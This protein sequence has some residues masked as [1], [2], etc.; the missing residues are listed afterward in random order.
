M[1]QITKSGYYLSLMGVIAGLANG[2]LGAGGGIIVIY[3]LNT[4]FKNEFTDEREVFANALCVMLP[5]SAVSCVG[6]A[7]MERMSVDGLSAFIIPAIVGGVC[8]GFLLGRINATFLKKLFA[9][10]VIYSGLILM[11]K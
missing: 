4:V 6:Y 8:G 2:L 7:F 3:A 9:V 1:R 5:I 10:I 11:I